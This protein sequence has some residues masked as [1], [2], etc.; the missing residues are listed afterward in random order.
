MNQC[1]HKK[2]VSENQ[3][4][5]NLDLVM[6]SIYQ[7]ASMQTLKGFIVV[8]YGHREIISTTLTYL[9]CNLTYDHFCTT[10]M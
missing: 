9:L 1:H 7:N 5:K 6:K 2:D 10:Q 3:T 4:C 8:S